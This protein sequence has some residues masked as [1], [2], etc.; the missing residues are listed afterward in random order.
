MS[1]NPSVPSS[2]KNYTTTAKADS[3]ASRH[4]WRTQDMDALTEIVPYKGPS[5]TLP[6][7]STISSSHQG[8]LHLPSAFSKAANGRIRAPFS[9]SGP[10]TPGYQRKGKQTF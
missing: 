6:D 10:P 9:P 7:N 4:Y 1:K 8:L 2:A 5:V 3:A